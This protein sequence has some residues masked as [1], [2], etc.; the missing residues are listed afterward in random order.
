MRNLTKAEIE[1]AY[2][3]N[4]GILIADEFE[5]RKKDYLAVPQFCV[6]I[7]EFLHGGKMRRKQCTMRS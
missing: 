1:E 6:K 5:V 7:T 3:K 4:T 2:E